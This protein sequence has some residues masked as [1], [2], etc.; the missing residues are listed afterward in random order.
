MLCDISVGEG[1]YFFFPRMRGSRP[2]WLHGKTQN[3]PICWNLPTW[4]FR[5]FLASLQGDDLQVSWIFFFL[6][7]V[8]TLVGDPYLG[9]LPI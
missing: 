2:S 4:R 7:G 9:D 8:V 3:K 1:L 5:C 6:V